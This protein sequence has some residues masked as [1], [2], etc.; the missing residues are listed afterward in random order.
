MNAG[1]M[2]IPAFLSRPTS[3]SEPFV[4]TSEPLNENSDTFTIEQRFQLDC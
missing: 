3:V 1:C 4:F 2:Y